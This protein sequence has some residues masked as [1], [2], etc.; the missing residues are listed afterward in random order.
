LSFSV[1][2]VTVGS[3]IPGGGIDNCGLRGG[4]IT[5]GWFQNLG[6]RKESLS[7][8]RGDAGALMG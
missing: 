6:L 1:R 7:S 8:K 5:V 4:D 2:G 3:A